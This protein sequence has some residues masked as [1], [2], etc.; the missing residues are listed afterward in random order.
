MRLQQCRS[1]TN[2][3]PDFLPF[4]VGAFSLHQ[5][6]IYRNSIRAPYR[7]SFCPSFLILS[8]IVHLFFHQ[9]FPCVAASSHDTAQPDDMYGRDVHLR[10]KI[11]HYLQNGG[12]Q[13]L[14]RLFNLPKHV[15]YDPFLFF[16]RD[17]APHPTSWSHSSN[18]HLR[19]DDQSNET[20][21]PRVLSDIELVRRMG[22]HIPGIDPEPVSRS[23]RP[24]TCENVK[25]RFTAGGGKCNFDIS[26]ASP[27]DVPQGVRES[28]ELAAKHWGARFISNVNIRICINWRDLGENTLGS[29]SNPVFVAGA[30]FETLRDDSH[31]QPALAAS[32]VGDDVIDSTLPHVVMNLNS[33]IPWHISTSSGAPPDRYDLSTIVLHELTHGLFFAGTIQTIG[34]ESARFI[35]NIPSRFDEFIEVEKDIA[36]LKNCEGEGLY[37]AIRSPNL[38]FHAPGKNIKMGLYAPRS[39]DT[40]SSVYH[41][42]NYTFEDDCR[43]NKIGVSGCSDLMTPV[44][45]QGYTRRNVGETTMRVYE[46]VRSSGAGLTK[47]QNC[48]VPNYTEDDVSTKN[49]V[50]PL[51]NIS[52]VVTASITG[53]ALVLGVIVSTIVTRG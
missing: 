30:N 3:S 38:R 17:N 35:D 20:Q 13:R 28:I 53:I 24:L 26:I 21:Q 49:F 15:Y 14:Q 10:A 36:V 48:S 2:G 47:V 5:D 4:V 25:L 9:Y 23:S 22:L 6:V 19:T 1:T 12:H 42:N 44:L 52:F 37:N 16:T 34:P 27:L 46:A 50:L 31:Y 40:G 32:L 39:F 51:W 18:H 7:K 33:G 11:N 43:Y 41:F 29:T 8:L 45:D